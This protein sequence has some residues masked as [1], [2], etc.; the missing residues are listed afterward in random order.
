M[1]LDVALAVIEQLSAPGDVVL[2]PM[3]GSGTTAAAT[4]ALGRHAIAF[5]SDTLASMLSFARCQPAPPE[6]LLTAAARVATHARRDSAAIDIKEQHV[7]LAG[8]N[9]VAFLDRWFLGEA[10]VQLF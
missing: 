6:R 4:L 7:G 3:A 9:E 2:D 10:Q 5:D 1:P 8:L